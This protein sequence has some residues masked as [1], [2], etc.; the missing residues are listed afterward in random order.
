MA[1]GIAVGT[2][3]QVLR[4]DPA[5]RKTDAQHGLSIDVVARG[6][7]AS[8]RRKQRRVSGWL[9]GRRSGPLGVIRR[10]NSQPRMPSERT[11]SIARHLIVR[12]VGDLL[13]R[14]AHFCLGQAAPARCCGIVSIKPAIAQPPAGPAEPTSSNAPLLAI[15]S[16]CFNETGRGA[17]GTVAP[18]HRVE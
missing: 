14:G 7:M 13:P 8:L 10:R 3:C 17:R 11:R 16:G 12:P 6:H 4:L 2:E 1:A 5:G 18:R 9:C 15:L